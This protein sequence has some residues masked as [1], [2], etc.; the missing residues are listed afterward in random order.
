VPEVP[1]VPDGPR[2]T[3]IGEAIVDLVPGPE[4]DCYL[5]KPGG[6]PFNVAIGLAR[7][8]HRTTLMARL[9]DDGFGKLL[10]CHAAAENIDL[11]SAPQA[12]EPATLAVVDLDRDA[13][14]S[15]SFYLQGTADWQW[16]GAETAA[17]PADTAVFHMGSL[18][19]W[20]SP[21][22]E[23]IHAMAAG[24]RHDGEVLISYDPNIRPAL[25]GQPARARPLVEKFV[26]LAHIVKASREDSDWLYPGASLER[27]SV[28]WLDLGPRLVV[29][30]DGPRGAHLFQAGVAPVHR[31]GR[32]VR[33]VD[34]IGAGDAFT[35]GLLGGLVRR[36]LHS[37]E[38]LSPS[39][40]LA[41]AVDEAILISALTCERAGADPPSAADLGFS[42]TPA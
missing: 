42:A 31:P 14:A 36:G 12:A 22:A 29:I 28:R 34:T 9:A 6:S 30:T 18:A 21:G 27:V 4:P 5:A 25:L 15:Y 26:S 39:A 35:S 37:P 1:D 11:G 17:L 3:V 23:R 33:V 24:L 19:S 2:V 7:L 40:P 41:E 10:R 13:N 16:T 20:L 8:G 32:E 38:L